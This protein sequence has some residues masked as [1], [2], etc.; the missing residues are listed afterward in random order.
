MS[1]QTIATTIES[2]RAFFATHT[3][4]D[5]DFR[6]EMLCTLKRAIIAY[7][8]RLYAAMYA[9]LHKSKFESYETEIGI[10][11]E[12]I[13][14]HLKNIKRWTKPEKVKT[15]IAHFYS[16][17]KIIREPYGVTLIVSPW[18]YPFQLLINPLVGAI[19]SG[20]CAILKPADY[21]PRTSQTIADMV[22]E[23]FRSDYIAVFTGGRTVNQA[24][25]E[26]RYDYIFFT[27]SPALGKIVMEKASRYLTPVSLELGGKSP[28]IVDSDAAIK[29]AAKR[30]AWGKLLN[31]G[32]TCIAPDYLFVHRSIKRELLDEIK[33]NIIKMYG[34]DPQKSVD[35]PRIV[36][37]KQFNHVI[38]LIEGGKIIFGGKVDAHDR[39]ISPTIIDNVKPDDAIMQEEIFGPVLPVLDFDNI[40]DV[41]RYVNVNPKPLAFYYFSESRA[42]QKYVLSRTTSGGGCIN[43]TIVHLANNNMP[44]GG[45]GNSG[46]GGYHGKYSVD[47]FSHKRSVLT[48]S[49]LFDIP[50]RYAPY[51]DK[52][53]LL[54]RILK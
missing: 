27:G 8:E 14:S 23:Y 1:E 53:K 28:C 43:D 36:N 45:V 24:L 9:D 44:F 52:I 34:D 6:K 13:G 33:S 40:D 50:V 10:V 20:N 22:R 30:I 19:S 25:L 37:E 29:V 15:G 3:T 35:Y 54:K 5:I 7:E 18:N 17:S 26:E 32:Q 21:T 51:A 16:T 11:L 48:K 38:K 49:T 47:A 42:K 41:I 2:Q 39:Y 31:A 12:E 4:K 46:M